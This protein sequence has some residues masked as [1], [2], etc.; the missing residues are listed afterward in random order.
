MRHFAINKQYS[1][2]ELKQI[3]KNENPPKNNSQFIYCFQN[4]LL[5]ISF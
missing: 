5:F 3:Q 4:V 2:E 1:I